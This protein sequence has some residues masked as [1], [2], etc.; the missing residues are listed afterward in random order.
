M[1]VA[2][3]SDVQANLP[4]FEEVVEHISSFAPDLVI[5]DGDLVN[6]GPSS[7]A[8][9]N[10]FDELRRERGWLPVRGNHEI[11]VQRCGEG[12]PKDR[13][14]AEMRGFTD[15]T[16]RQVADAIEQ[17]N[18]WPD[19]LSFSTTAP[20]SW[21]HVT[22]GSMVGNRDGIS[23]SVTDE[24]LVD[25]VPEDVALFVTGHTHRVHQRRLGDLEI[26]NVGS[27][28]SP[29]D[30]DPRASYARL[31]HVDGGWRV[32]IVRL[33][34]DRDRARRDF[35]DTGFIDEGGPLARIIL[36]EWSRATGLMQTFLRHYGEAV[37]T[38]EIELGQAVDQFLS[39][40]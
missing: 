5:L 38:E 6:R 22:H 13:Y 10:L 31:H 37:R 2:V 4:A 14:D 25:K 24:Q 21:V 12:P 26:V 29:F 11:W 15:W 17:L 30:D 33:G 32:E 39:S 34:Y 1:K 3:F 18:D 19:H 28:G 36:E 35:Y 7:L 8:C 16:Y 40:L 27:A 20:D 9:L 23:A